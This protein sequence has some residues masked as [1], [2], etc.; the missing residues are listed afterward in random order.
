VR[1]LGYAAALEILLRGRTLDAHEAVV[2]GLASGPSED[3]VGDAVELAGSI[4]ETDP[5]LAV[6]IKRTTRLAAAGADFAT[7]LDAETTAQAQSAQS[8][9]LRAW[10]D[11]FRR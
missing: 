8:D 6:Q 1:Q 7:V 4:A 10:V 2:R 5:L 11:R 9:Q 3:P